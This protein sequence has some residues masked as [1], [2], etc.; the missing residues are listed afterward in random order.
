[1][2]TSASVLSNIINKCPGENYY[3]LR[4]KCASLLNSLKDFDDRA[5]AIMFCLAQHERFQHQRARQKES[6]DREVAENIRITERNKAI[7]SGLD[8]VNS[9]TKIYKNAKK[10]DKR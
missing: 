9:V 4:K 3:E 8:I 7:N 10:V 6:H 1:M 5:E 2:H